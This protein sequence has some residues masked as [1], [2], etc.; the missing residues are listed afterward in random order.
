MDKFSKR[1][2]ARFCYRNLKIPFVFTKVVVFP[3]FP[4]LPLYNWHFSCLHF[5]NPFFIKLGLLF[6]YIKAKRITERL[7]KISVKTNGFLDGKLQVF[8]IVHLCTPVKNDSYVKYN[9][10]SIFHFDTYTTCTLPYDDGS[11]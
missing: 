8:R 2:D 6:W 1:S 11:P 9:I 3:L 10:K 7:S 5:R 4:Y